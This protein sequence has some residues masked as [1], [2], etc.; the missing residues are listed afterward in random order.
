MVWPAAAEIVQQSVWEPDVL[1]GEG[2]GAICSDIVECC[3][4]LDKR[5]CGSQLNWNRRAEAYLASL[6]SRIVVMESE[7]QVR[8]AEFVK[9][10]LSASPPD[11]GFER[12]QLCSVLHSTSNIL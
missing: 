7:L 1:A 12:F 10:V 2:L 3:E 9:P 5:V 4:M 11:E 6:L 8:H